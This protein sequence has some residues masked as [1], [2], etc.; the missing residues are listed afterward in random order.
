M[1]DRIP[2]YP[3]RVILTP[4]PGQNNTYDMIRADQPQQEGTPLNKES[5]LTDETAAAIASATKIANSSDPVINE[6]LA[7]IAAVIGTNLKLTKT[8]SYVGTGTK[9][10]NNAIQLAIGFCPV[11]VVVLAADGVG[12]GFIIYNKTSNTF[13]SQTYDWKNNLIVQYADGILSQY[14]TNV[15]SSAVYYQ[16]NEASTNYYWVAIGE[17]MS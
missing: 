16:L 3:G 8:G 10:K 12:Q 15:S 7:N 13:G 4:V 2:L 11:F 17:G 14:T 5:F 1:K 6:M 9:G